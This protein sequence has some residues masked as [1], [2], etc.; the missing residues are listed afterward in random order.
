[1]KNQTKSKSMNHSLN[2]ILITVIFLAGLLT[3]FTAERY[4][5]GSAAL[6]VIRTIAGLLMLSGP[7]LHF[8]RGRRHYRSSDLASINAARCH[9]WP[10]MWKITVIFS[11]VAWAAW[12]QVTKNSPGLTATGRILF[13]LWTVP[14]ITGLI[15][16]IGIEWAAFKGAQDG[17][18]ARIARASKA[19]TAAGLLLCT[20]IAVNYAAVRR[21]VS[22][23]WSYLKITEPSEATTNIA[24][25]S[26]EPITIAIFYQRENE[27]LPWVEGYATRLVQTSEGRVSL[28][29]IDK[30]LD[31]IGAAHFKTSRN[32]MVIVEA[33]TRQERIDLGP[34]LGAA[35]P[36][37]KKLDSEIQRLLLTLTSKPKTAYVMRGHGELSPDGSNKA[38]PLESSKLL[39]GFLRDQNWIIKTFGIAEG[40]ASRVPDDATALLLLGPATPLIGA[41][42]ESLKEFT[43]RGGSLLVS[44]DSDKRQDDLNLWLDSIG[45]QFDSHPVANEKNHVAATRSPVDNWFLFTTSFSSHDSIKTLAKNDDRVAVLAFGSGSFTVG[46]NNASRN[47]ADSKP[48]ALI[49]RVTETVRSLADSFIDQ[50]RNYRFDE[51]IEKRGATALGVA[52]VTSPASGNPSK[53]VIFGDTA[54]FSD[55]L[56]RNPG[57]LAFISDSMKWL[58]GEQALSGKLADEEDVRIRQTGKQDLI[59]FYGS[60]VFVPLSVLLAGA[61]FIRRRTRA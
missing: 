29:V 59:W 34:T 19:W 50:N 5:S 52:A 32:G 45:I 57:N 3:L 24:K 31:P 17:D 51:K 38:S 2:N 22:R 44:L 49:W 9:F 14:L 43:A 56:I 8:W 48:A 15:A 60:I 37:L 54:A 55:A 39:E 16:A 33:G 7:A 46:E 21:D 18:P 13:G 40:S 4:F 20:L 11:I 47:P 27:V 58:A 10:T 6:N 41:E 12:Q 53:M 28:K 26:A 36:L 25:A 30:D 35:R 61:A 1:M 42:I 23:D